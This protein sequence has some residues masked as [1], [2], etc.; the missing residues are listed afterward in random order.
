VRK[1]SIY[2]ESSLETQE[3][4]FDSRKT[5][6]QNLFTYGL[7][8][9]RPLCSGLGLCGQC[10]IKFVSNSPKPKPKDLQILSPRELELG[11]RLACIHFPESNQK[12]EI[13]STKD[14]F[15]FSKKSQSPAVCLG[16]DLGTT[17]I[18]WALIHADKQVS[19]GQCLNPQMGA[20]AEVVSRL[21][22]ALESEKNRQLLTTL[23]QAKVGQIVSKAGENKCPLVLAG[24][25]AMI[26]L[27]L[28]LEV[29]ELSFAPFNLNYWGG[30]EELLNPDIPKLYIPPLLGAF[31]GAD[32]SA[33]LTYIEFERD[34]DGY[35]YLF[36]DLGTNG[37]MVLVK[38]SRTFL[39]TSVA[40]G[41]ALEGVGLRFGSVFG[42]ND[43]C[44]RFF[45]TPSGLSGWP[46]KDFRISGSGYLSLIGILLQ[47][48][49]L[50]R[51]GHFQEGR[52]PLARKVQARLQE[53]RLYLT[54][55]VYLSAHDI[56]EILKVKAAFNLAINYL[57]EKAGLTFRD[58]RRI[59][60][61][62]AFGQHVQG[63]SLEEL[64]FLPQ[65]MEAKTSFV[66]NTALKGSVLLCQ[67]ERARNWVEGLKDRVR[68]INLAHGDYL[69]E[70][71]AKHMRFSFVDE[72]RRIG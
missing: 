41:P 53:N 21:A 10:K 47:L 14:Y 55:E 16:I 2:L 62:G 12:I 70:N 67:D 7:I 1:I 9:E 11:Y 63:G 44:S 59:F 19:K 46:Q 43:V 34:E 52:H 38:D 5:Y 40:M 27:F 31:V 8:R 18:K 26:Y 64:G 49:I 60:I 69:A 28:G 4:H 68:Y 32:I 6:A 36:C 3:L 37:E 72:D 23:V 66:G 17:T 33:G 35:P 42:D 39:C 54:E 45:L 24:N 13:P 50:D 25:P 51:N 30:C 56:E 20:G 48:G 57:L 65:G 58:I 15:N 61:A 29:R 71:F 22:F